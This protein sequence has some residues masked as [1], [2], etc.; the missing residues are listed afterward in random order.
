MELTDFEEFSES[1]WQKRLII[2][3][4]VQWKTKYLERV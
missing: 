2:R 3:R 1:T 4:T